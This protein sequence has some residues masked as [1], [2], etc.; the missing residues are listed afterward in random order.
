VGVEGEKSL[1]YALQVHGTNLHDVLLFLALQNPVSTAAGHAYNIE[2]LCAINH[3]V[4]LCCR[5]SLD[6]SRWC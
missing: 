1:P 6:S 2:K 3:V 4:I 5:V